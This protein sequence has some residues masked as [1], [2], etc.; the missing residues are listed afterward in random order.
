MLQSMIYFAHWTS[1]SFISDQV[2]WSGSVSAQNVLADID[3]MS[4]FK[5]PLGSSENKK[6]KIHRHRLSCQVWSNVDT[7]WDTWQYQSIRLSN[8]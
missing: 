7:S 5:L 8:E 1:T 3:L 6:S 4:N 2:T